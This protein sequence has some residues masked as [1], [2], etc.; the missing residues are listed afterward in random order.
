MNTTRL[1]SPRHSVLSFFLL[2]TLASCATLPSA[3]VT[4]NVPSDRLSHE[5]YTSPDGGYAVTLPHLKSGARIEE[6]QVTPA[7]N[8]VRFT[9]RPIR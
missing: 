1:T 6:R 2:V 8:G 4:T 9:A 7:K 3:S 5:T